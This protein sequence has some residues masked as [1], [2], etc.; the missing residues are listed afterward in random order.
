MPSLSA[1]VTILCLYGRTIARP[2]LCIWPLYNGESGK[3]RR[4]ISCVTL[5]VYTTLHSRCRNSRLTSGRYEN[6][7]KSSSPDCGTV[8][9]QWTERPSIRTGVPVFILSASKPKLRSC[10]C[11]AR[12][13]GSETLPPGIRTRPI[14]IRPL[15]K[16]PAVS[17]IFEALKV[18]PNAVTTPLASPSSMRR[19]NDR[20]PPQIKARSVF[21]NVTPFGA[22]P[23][24]VA[25]G[26]RTPHGR[27][28]GTVELSQT[29]WQN[30]R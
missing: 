6:L 3:P 10:S 4:K 14:C 2:I 5:F 24:T 28:F 23:H 11:Y 25:L 15:R 8:S 29:G 18:M 1:K 19:E 7:W 12:D 13:A 27:A 16:V 26:T 17:T 22:E 9:S 20:I 21:K 30:G